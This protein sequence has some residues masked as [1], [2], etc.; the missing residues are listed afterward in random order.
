MTF[1]LELLMKSFCSTIKKGREEFIKWI[2]L[3]LL[4]R[5]AAA[6]AT[7]TSFVALVVVGEKIK[8]Q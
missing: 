2:Q 1:I 5:A 6:A 7:Y 4:S 3:L 8:S